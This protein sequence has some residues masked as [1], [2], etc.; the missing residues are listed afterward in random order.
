VDEQETSWVR[1]IF[2]EREG[3]LYIGYE[4]SRGRRVKAPSKDRRPRVGTWEAL[5]LPPASQFDAGPPLLPLAI[6]WPA[7]AT[8]LLLG[9]AAALPTVRNTS[10]GQTQPTA[11]AVLVRAP[12]G[13]PWDQSYAQL[14]RWVL[15]VV[16]LS[17]Q[18][19]AVAAEAPPGSALPFTSTLTFT[20]PFDVA[21]TLPDRGQLASSVATLLYALKPEQQPFAMRVRDAELSSD[22]SADYADILL[23]SI[24]ELMNV[25][26]SG[27]RTPPRLIVADDR[28][29]RGRT[30]QPETLP[31]GTSLVTLHP[32]SRPEPS[33]FMAELLRELTHDLPLHEAVLAAARNLRYSAEEGSGI[34]VYTSPAGLDSLRLSTAFERFQARTQSIARY[35]SVGQGVSLEGADLHVPGRSYLIDDAAD[36]ARLARN[37]FMGESS[38]LSQMARAYA[39][40]VAATPDMEA[41]RTAATA[42]LADPILADDLAAGQHRRATIWMSHDPRR[43]APDRSPELDQHVVLARD[44]GY[45]LNVAVGMDVPTDLVAPDVPSIDPIL[46]PTP[47]GGHVLDVAVYADTA[48][49]TGPSV[50]QFRLG[51]LGPSETVS[52]RLRTPRRGNS[53]R[54]R[55]LI[56]YREHIV[57][58]FALHLSIAAAEQRHI[59]SRPAMRTELIYSRQEQLRDL[60]QLPRR[61]LSIAAN[62]DTSRGT[63]RLMFGTT[64]H[65]ITLSEKTVDDARKYMRACMAEAFKGLDTLGHLAPSDFGRVVKAMASRGS[66]LHGSLYDAQGD[67]LQQRLDAVSNA[68]NGTVQVVR[69]EPDFAYPWTMLYDWH[70]PLTE[71]ALDA[72]EVCT[73]GN[74]QVPCA[75]EPDSGGV[76]VR[77]FWGVRLIIEELVRQDDTDEYVHTVAGATGSP[78]VLCTVGVVDDWVRDMVEGLENRFGGTRFEDLT[79]ATSLLTR[80]WDQQGRPAVLV[81]VGHLTNTR[82]PSEPNRPRIYITSSER[83]LDT[84]ALRRAKQSNGTQRWEQPHR[85]IVLLLGCD[86]GRSGLGEVHNFVSSLS[87]AGAAA[88]VATEEKIDTRLAGDLASTIV[89][90]LGQ[91]GAGES[92]RAWRARLMTER[93]PLG[94]V[95]TCFGSSGAHVPELVP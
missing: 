49:V 11:L 22:L 13:R 36:L 29:G 21:N 27:W 88:I 52:F 91:T 82:K 24:A 44:R 50:Q 9:M 8:R 46:P 60:D 93:N 14:A 54:I 42:L 78:A 57:Q 69:L 94:M 74:A 64:G 28:T 61:L 67:S 87:S 45:V 2:T 31:A 55:V 38:G 68:D 77:G 39:A 7:R 89:P 56:Y 80:L 5:P 4:D 90:A 16:G 12:E 86:T 83:F 34:S 79:V 30:L 33:E 72:A 95:F 47:E 18:R 62:E 59:S 6:M 41:I 26:A 51:Q 17:G 66:E 71:A 92:L 53:T 35:R 43:L 81:V 23:T 85:P 73:G 63:H 1:L 10:I 76:C 20:L 84:V 19:S 58:A 3:V 25:A 37:D 40:Q 75:C 48:K 65:S 70:L 15:D 32:E